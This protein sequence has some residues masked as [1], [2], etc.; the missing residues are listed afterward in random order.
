MIN[1]M[2]ALGGIVYLICAAV[3][4]SSDK[5]AGLAHVS[6]HALFPYAG[7]FVAVAFVTMLLVRHGDSKAA[8]ARGL[9]V[10]EDL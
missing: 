3:L 1:L 6:Y 2:G 4:Y 8:P 10:F 5:T 9:E 7:R